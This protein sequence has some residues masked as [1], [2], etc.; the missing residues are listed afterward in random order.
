VPATIGTFDISLSCSGELEAH[1]QVEIRNPLDSKAVITE[2][3]DEGVTVEEGD[4]L[5]RFAEEEILARV[6]GAEDRVHTAK[7]ALVAAEMRLR[8]ERSARD[9]DLERARLAVELAELALQAW[10]EG[11]LLSR[12]QQLAMDFETARIDAE[13]LA[14]K[15]ADSTGLLEA[16]FIS[17][18]E[19]E[20]DRIAMLEAEARFERARLDVEV[21]ERFE[22]PQEQARL[23][24]AAMRA[25]EERDRIAVRYTAA[26][27]TAEAD[28]ASAR[29]RLES[30]EE[31][32]ADLRQQRAACVMRA[33]SAGLVVYASSFR[34]RNWRGTLPPPQI[35]TE[36]KPNELVILLPDTSWMAASVEVNESLRGLVEPGQR[37]I[38]RPD[39]MPDA[40]FAAEVDTVGILARSGGWRDP[41]R[42]DYRVRLALRPGE[43]RGLK[44]SMRCRATILIDRV[45][46]ALHVP[47]QSVFRSDAGERIVYVQERGGIRPR[48]VTIGRA[49]EH[50][51]EILDGLT[52]GERVLTRAPRPGE[53]SG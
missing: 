43:G 6:N 52:Q 35:G 32:L 21:Y 13:R 31:R 19:C 7:A 40:E 39:A 5:V 1:E 9:S 23:E 18:D 4:V 20:R 28:V 38:V 15:H 2:I 44:P 10:S 53:R 46:N 16:G 27:R 45:E 49:S 50:A 37:A 36:L 29:H 33:P 22:R 41:N 42:R 11:I 14:R 48:R 8:I 51:V 24:A 47:V 30:H 26:L 25:R 34:S 3:V 12:R 17:R